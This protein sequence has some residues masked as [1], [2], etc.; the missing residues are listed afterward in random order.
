[1]EQK[2]KEEEVYN[3]K[4]RSEL[5]EFRD[6]ILMKRETEPSPIKEDHPAQREGLTRSDQYASLSL[7]T[8]NFLPPT[9]G[10]SGRIRILRADRVK[11]RASPVNLNIEGPLQAEP[12]SMFTR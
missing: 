7:R 2:A 8:R 6:S 1:V 4:L 3:E 10:S 11:K 12:P 5:K 9:S